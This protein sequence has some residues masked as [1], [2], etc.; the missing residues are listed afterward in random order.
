M[1]NLMAVDDHIR[2]LAWSL[3][4][5]Q[6][7]QLNPWCQDGDD[8]HPISSLFY[9]GEHLPPTRRAGASEERETG[10]VLTWMKPYHIFFGGG[11]EHDGRKDEGWFA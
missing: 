2:S 11:D 1:D 10:R 6:V 5:R 4:V 7:Q 3:P 8:D 9:T